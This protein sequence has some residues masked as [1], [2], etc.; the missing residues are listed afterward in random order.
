MVR[1][2]AAGTGSFWQRKEV[3]LDY[4]E[5]KALKLLILVFGAL[6]FTRVLGGTRPNLI[7]ISVDTLRQDH[8]SIY[9]YARNATPNADRLMRTG[10]WFSSAHCN[11]P[12][13]SPG[14][15]S[16]MTSRYPHE[17][18][19]TRN[20][21]PMVNDLETL[22]EIL[23]KNGYATA[24]F[25]S[26][27]PLKKNISNL[28]K[29]FDLYDDDFFRKRWIFFNSERDAQGVTRQASA[30]IDSNPQQPFFLWAH[31]SDPHQ[32]YLFHNGFNFASKTQTPNKA[33][34]KINAYDSE[35][36]YADYHVGVLLNRLRARG[37]DQNSL[38]VFIADHGEELGEHGYTGHGRYLYEPSMRIP[39]G[40]S[41]PGIPAGKRVDAQ[42]ELLDLAPTML[43]YAGIAPGAAMRGRNLMPFILGQKSWPEHFLVYFETYPGAVRGEGAEKMVNVKDPI[44]IGL[45]LDDLKVCFHPSGARW[46]MYDLAGDAKEI[47]N[48]ADPADQTFIRFSDHLLAW[49]R[50]WE[51]SAVSGQPD[52][53]T[54]E[55]KKRLEA[56]GY[57][58]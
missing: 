58:K 37:L 43:A 53:M 5:M 20:G 25:L 14:F 6:A 41:G 30:W 34:D 10:A 3:M 46:E 19:S 23:K 36:A 49:R 27:W 28:Q 18:G 26:N 31:Y 21:V 12:L 7:L 8:V 56:L 32:P 29:G 54:L 33:Q 44:W 4:P 16:L 48:L 2:G 11:I 47:R 39:F 55:D 9:G 42:I 57:L 50:V 13:T 17:T 24:A 40:L 38:I 35:I 15:A 1:E 52:A 45:K 51:K 22:A